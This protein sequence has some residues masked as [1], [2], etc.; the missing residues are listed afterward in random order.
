MAESFELKCHNCDGECYLYL[1]NV[2]LKA[3]FNTGKDKDMALCSSTDFLP[4]FKLL[5]SNSE[6]VRLG[7]P[8]IASR[9]KCN[10]DKFPAFIPSL[11]YMMTHLKMTLKVLLKIFTL[12]QDPSKSVRKAFRYV[13]MM[14]FL[15]LH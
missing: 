8:H 5:A 4:F 12:M 3:L 2:A 14:M 1:L 15:I 10:T 7:K 6:A 13:G 9:I 11:P